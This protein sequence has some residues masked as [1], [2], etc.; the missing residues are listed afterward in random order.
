MAPFFPHSPMASLPVFFMGNNKKKPMRIR[1]KLRCSRL[2]RIILAS[3]L[4][5]VAVCASAQE[6]T[7]SPQ[8]AP[9]FSG[10]PLPLTFTQQFVLTNNLLFASPEN[11]LRNP[12]IVYAYHD[13]TR[14]L[15]ILRRNNDNQSGT[16]RLCFEIVEVNDSQALWQMESSYTARQLR[17][18][19]L[20]SDD[21]QSEHADRNVYLAISED[22]YNKVLSEM[23]DQE[24]STFI[25]NP[26]QKFFLFQTQKSLASDDPTIQTQPTDTPS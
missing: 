4:C 23:P 19:D 3:A 17:V 26:A 9:S 11:Q 18:D 20:P 25:Q 24:A 1:Q 22:D 6:N 8:G 21:N 13:P 12:E 2:E 14:L 15:N 16:P 10:L 5:L 7:S